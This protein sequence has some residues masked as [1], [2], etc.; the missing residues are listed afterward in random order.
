MCSEEWEATYLKFIRIVV[1][2]KKFSKIL[3]QWDIEPR[4]K[5]LDLCCGTGGSIKVFRKAG[6]H[7]VYGLDI[8]LNLLGRVKQGIPVLLADANACPIKNEAFDVVVIHKALHHFL[9]HHRLL[10]EIKRIL[11]PDGIFCFIE[12]RK[13]WFRKLYHVALLSPFAELFP[14]LLRMRHAALIEE[15]KTYFK[16]LDNTDE[17][18]DLLE[19]RFSFTTESRRDDFMHHIVKCRSQKNSDSPL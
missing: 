12:P 7:N 10:A 17:F 5:I 15:G 1:N 11:K 13:T 19:N 4:A 6:Y 2:P 16:W 14:P 9:D 8:S 3:R 18:F